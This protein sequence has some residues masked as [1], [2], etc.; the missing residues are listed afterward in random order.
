MPLG[1]LFGALGCHFAIILVPR[2]AF[3]GHFGIGAAP[4]AN[5]APGYSRGICSKAFLADFW[6][7]WDS[8]GIQFGTTNQ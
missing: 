2:G 4:L 1:S 8:F 7:F 6:H 3:W 5:Q